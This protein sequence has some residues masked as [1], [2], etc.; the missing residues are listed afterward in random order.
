MRW[1]P[2]ERMTPAEAL[3][4]EWILEGISPIVVEEIRSTIGSS[5]A[6][7]LLTSKRILNHLKRQTPNSKELSTKLR[8]SP[9]ASKTSIK[10]RQ[11]RSISLNKQYNKSKRLEKSK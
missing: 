6:G 2:S 3:E 9:Y 5:G 11:T 7:D 1:V 4:D 10:T 8:D